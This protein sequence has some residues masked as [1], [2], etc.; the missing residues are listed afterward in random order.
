MDFAYLGKKIKEERIKRNLTQQQISEILNISDAYYGQIE[1][2]QRH[3]TLEKL[4]EVA[5]YFDTSVDYLLCG[6]LPE[7]NKTQADEW[8]KL[9]DGKTPKEKRLIL[10][11]VDMLTKY[12]DSI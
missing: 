8:N 12:L 7:T 3:I 6:S 11:F 5:Q 9:T 4:V 2:G 1:R 10:G